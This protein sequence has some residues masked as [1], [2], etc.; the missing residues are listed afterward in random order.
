MTLSFGCKIMPTGLKGSMSDLCVPSVN[1]SA[2]NGA[3]LD[4]GTAVVSADIRIPG[5][6]STR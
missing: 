1:E 6:Y 3:T 2:A 4:A 5:H